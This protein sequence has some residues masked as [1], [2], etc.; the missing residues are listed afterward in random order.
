MLSDE[1]DPKEKA[2]RREERKSYDVFKMKFPNYDHKDLKV[3]L[4]FYEFIVAEAK[5]NE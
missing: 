4:D 5:L 3:F 2:K 1:A